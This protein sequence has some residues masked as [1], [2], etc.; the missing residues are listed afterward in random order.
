LINKKQPFSASSAAARIFNRANSQNKTAG[1]G[2]IYGASS[3]STNTS[4]SSFADA[5][6]KA[7][8]EQTFG[9]KSRRF[10]AKLELKEYF[11]R[12]AGPGTYKQ[13][14]NMEDHL[15]HESMSTKGFLNGFASKCNRFQV[16]AAEQTHDP[17]ILLGPGQ[18][19]PKPVEKNVLVPKLAPKGEFSLPFNEKNPLNF[20]KPITV[21][22]YFK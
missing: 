17:T 3:L 5:S 16:S 6:K 1:N 19:D 2:S 15:A 11:N 18:Y 4:F 10:D 14:N 12:E 21:N 20:V 9:V 22:I 7:K 8:K 13:T